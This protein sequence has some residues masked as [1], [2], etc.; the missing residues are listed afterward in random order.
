MQLL[1]EH[2]STRLSMAQPGK[3][4]SMAGPPPAR[5]FLQGSQWSISP[6]HAQHGPSGSGHAHAWPGLIYGWPCARLGAG[7]ALVG[8]GCRAAAP[9]LRSSRGEFAGAGA[10]SVVEQ[11]LSGENSGKMGIFLITNRK[12]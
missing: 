2:G 9:W 7:Y 4:S 8:H 6:G 1:H 10:W 12:D 3:D 5:P 11:G